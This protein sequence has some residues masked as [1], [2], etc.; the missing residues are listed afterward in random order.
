MKKLLLI[1]LVSSF[2]LVSCSKDDDDP[3]PTPGT[4]KYMTSTVGST[5]NYSYTDDNDP[6]NNDTYTVTSINKDTSANA[7]SYHV[8]TN[9]GSDNEYYNITG[10]DYY[11]LQAFSLAGT[12]TILENLYLKDNAALNFGWLQTYTVDVS[13]T[14]IEVRLT[15]KIEEKGIT[16]TVGSTVYT[17]VIHIVTT[18]D[19]PILVTLPGSSLSTDI[20]YY[21]A[22]KVGLIQNDSKIDLVAP[23]LTLDEHTDVHTILQSATIL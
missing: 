10:N 23:L 7:K 2:I 5:W 15:N 4:D 14:D 3:V 1:T 18:I 6:S 8:F 11:T 17:N 22:P 16:K 12:D 9:S 19:I 13:G 20:H 21:Y